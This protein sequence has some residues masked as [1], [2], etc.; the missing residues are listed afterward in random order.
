[1]WAIL[2]FF[3]NNSDLSPLHPHLSNPLFLCVGWFWRMGLVFV[4][5]FV[6]LWVCLNTGK[7]C[8]ESP[9]LELRV[10][11]SPLFAHNISLVTL[12]HNLPLYSLL[13]I[14]SLYSL[15]IFSSFFQPFFLPFLSLTLSIFSCLSSVSH[16][17]PPDSLSLRFSF[18]S[19][20][21]YLS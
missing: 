12:F 21:L 3:R 9:L 11:E 1:M 20:T 4:W 7:C 19:F 2:Q 13:S 10:A 8:L 18:I 16:P 14:S 6:S 17:I 5:V 15:L